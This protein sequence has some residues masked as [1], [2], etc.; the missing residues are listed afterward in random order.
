MEIRDASY[1][2]LDLSEKVIWNEYSKPMQKALD[3]ASRVN[4]INVIRAFSALERDLCFE[5]SIKFKHDDIFFELVEKVKTHQLRRCSLLTVSYDRLLYFKEIVKRIPTSEFVNYDC[6][7]ELAE[8]IIYYDRD[9][10]LENLDLNSPNERKVK[11]KLEKK[12]TKDL[13]ISIF[14]SNSLSILI[15]FLKN[16]K[17]YSFKQELLENLEYLCELAV[18]KQAINVLNFLIIEFYDEME[19][20]SETVMRSLIKWNK[21]NHTISAQKYLVTQMIRLMMLHFDFS[22]IPGLINTDTL[23][24]IVTEE[25]LSRM[26]STINNIK[27][28]RT[29]KIRDL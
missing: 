27:K 20:I 2:S 21:M 28:V 1:Y 22:N 23:R 13:L 8:K 5:K 4:Y 6:Y 14:N 19:P 9:R 15:Y 25:E 29:K 18:H 24:T 7:V 3:G 12:K 17:D 26:I 16:D 11:E 10:F